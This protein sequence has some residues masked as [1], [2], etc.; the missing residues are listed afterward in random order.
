VFLTAGHCVTLDD[1]GTVATSARVC[2]EQD[3]AADAPGYPTTGGIASTEI[4]DYGYRGLDEIPESK[5]AG[6]LVLDAPVQ[7]AVPG[8]RRVRITRDRRLARQLQGCTPGQLRHDGIGIRGAGEQRQP[9]E[10]GRL[11]RAAHRRELRHRAGRH[12][13]RGLRR[14]AVDQPGRQPRRGDPRRVR[15]RTTVVQPLVTDDR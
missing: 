15:R 14:E 4:Y 10:A 8:H 13:H 1:E 5:D 11:P 12:Q 6:V 9:D 7:T 2:F 3:V